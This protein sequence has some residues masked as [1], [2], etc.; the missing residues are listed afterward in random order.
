MEPPTPVADLGYVHC[1]DHSVVL[2]QPHGL[3][4]GDRA[5]VRHTWRSIPSAHSAATPHPQS[6]PM[7][8]GRVAVA[9]AWL[10]LRLWLWLWQSGRCV[11]TVEDNM[12]KTPNW[13]CVSV[14]ILLQQNE[15]RCAKSSVHDPKPNNLTQ[16]IKG[17]RNTTILAY[18]SVLVLC[19]VFVTWL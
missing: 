6:Q 18:P 4:L 17:H 12:I 1:S 11:V 19:G 9:V 2:R 5:A 14:G 13:P 10:W 15:D 3:G 7:E 8:H 16:T